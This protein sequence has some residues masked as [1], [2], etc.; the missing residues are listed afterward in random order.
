MNQVVYTQRP[1]VRCPRHRRQVGRQSTRAGVLWLNVEPTF[2]ERHAEGRPTTDS[3]YVAVAN[4]DVTYP[5]LGV[6]RRGKVVMAATVTGDD[7]Y[8]E[9]VV[10]GDQ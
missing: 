5:A 1:S 10:H 3:G 8:P 6:S 7:H 9:R 2:E 4:N